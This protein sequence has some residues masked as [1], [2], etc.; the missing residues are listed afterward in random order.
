[1]N[2]IEAVYKHGVFNPIG[3]PGLADGQ[4][5]RIVLESENNR[6][7]KVL[8]KQIRSTPQFRNITKDEEQIEKAICLLDEWMADDS[9]YD[10]ETWIELK[11]ALNRERDNVS[12]RRLFD[13]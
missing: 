9:G 10:K 1:M 4:R 3:N 8:S 12:A 6:N 13:D 11:A 2:I 5:V 7:F